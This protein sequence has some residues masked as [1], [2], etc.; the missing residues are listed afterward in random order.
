MIVTGTNIIQNLGD[1]QDLDAMSFGLLGKLMLDKGMREGNKD[2]KYIS[3]MSGLSTRKI[4]K[5]LNILEQTG[6]IKRI[7]LKE[8]NCRYNQV[9]IKIKEAA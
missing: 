7:M 6:Y 5:H 1:L 9:E 8:N 4:A 2:I 3:R